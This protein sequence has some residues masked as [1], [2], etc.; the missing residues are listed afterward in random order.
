[1]SKDTTKDTTPTSRVFVSQTGGMWQNDI[2]FGGEQLEPNVTLDTPYVL[3]DCGIVARNVKTSIG[4]DGTKC[5]VVISQIDSNGE[6]SEPRKYGTFASSIASKIEL[7]Q[8]GDLPAI[9]KFEKVESS[10]WDTDAFVMTFV[11]HFE[12]NPPA[13]LPS[14]TTV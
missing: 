9:V 1:M 5:E 4:D 7:R 2:V 13:N 3:W 10:T 8:D 14:I 11:A 6:V 12:G